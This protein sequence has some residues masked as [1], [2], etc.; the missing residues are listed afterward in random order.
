MTSVSLAW[1]RNVAEP[2]CRSRSHPLMGTGIIAWVTLDRETLSQ[3]KPRP[4]SR[5]ALWGAVALAALAVFEMF[6][7]K[8][9]NVG[10]PPAAWYPDP[11]GR[12]ALRYWDGTVWTDHTA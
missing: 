3:A 8:R 7:R 1:P 2:K 11:L 5:L 12:A 4:G 9:P 10:G 6:L